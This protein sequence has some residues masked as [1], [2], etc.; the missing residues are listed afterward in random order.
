MADGVIGTKTRT[1][2]KEITQ[3]LKINY[4][5]SLAITPSYILNLLKIIKSTDISEYWC[6][7]NYDAA[8]KLLNNNKY[9]LA[10]LEFDK[11]INALPNNSLT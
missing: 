3:K 6:S 5:D 9:K 2:L 11:L 1:A 4:S 7:S 10:V 8:L